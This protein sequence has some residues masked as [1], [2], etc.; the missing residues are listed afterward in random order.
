[1]VYI[2][3]TSSLRVLQNYFPDSFPA[4]WQNWE[5]E[6]AFGNIIS[7]REVKRELDLLAV[8]EHLI[9][10]LDSNR[11]VFLPPT[12]SESDFVAQIFS[13]PHFR[14]LISAQNQLK[15]MRSL[16]RLSLRQLA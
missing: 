8:S 9:D 13:V 14:Q 15:G 10:W 6:V 16:T 2:F 7:V 5:Q 4:F 3:D 12:E 11:D 1:M